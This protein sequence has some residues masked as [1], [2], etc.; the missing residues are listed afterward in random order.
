[1]NVMMYQSVGKTEE[2]NQ[3][4]IEGMRTWDANYKC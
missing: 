2:A 4:C 3:E 1:L